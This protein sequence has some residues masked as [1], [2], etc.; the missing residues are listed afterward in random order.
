MNSQVGYCNCACRDCFEIA[1]GIAG[2]ALCSDCEDSGCEARVEQEC[3]ADGA[4]GQGDEESE[5]SP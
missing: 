3:Q 1:I 4:Y 5:V 2:E